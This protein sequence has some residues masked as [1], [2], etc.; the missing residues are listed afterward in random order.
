MATPLYISQCARRS[1]VV[2]LT[3]VG[4]GLTASDKG[5]LVTV[6]GVSEPT[7][8]GVFPIDQVTPPD[9]I[10]YKQSAALHDIVNGLSGGA[11][12]IG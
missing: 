12:A 4:H 7:I 9:T 10:R 11:V 8:N 1:G 3:V 2:H 6:V 5:R